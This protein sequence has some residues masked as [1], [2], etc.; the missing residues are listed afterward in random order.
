[1]RLTQ[2]NP[3]DLALRAA[4]DAIKPSRTGEPEA[5]RGQREADSRGVLMTQGQRSLVTVWRI[6]P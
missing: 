5:G 1:M 4:I 6:K 3:P 2:G